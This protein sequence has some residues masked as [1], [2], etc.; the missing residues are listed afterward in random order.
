MRFSRYNANK[1]SFIVVF[2]K[3]NFI[4]YDDV[5]LAM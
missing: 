1:V 4:C 5:M 2:I 3:M